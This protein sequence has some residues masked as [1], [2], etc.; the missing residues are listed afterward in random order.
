MS[1]K[2]LF[3]ALLV[4]VFS[5]AQSQRLIGVLSV[6]HKNAE[7]KSVSNLYEV[8]GSSERDDRYPE[9]RKMYEEKL[10]PGASAWFE[11]YRNCD[12]WKKII[13]EA[14]SKKARKN[15]IVDC[16]PAINDRGEP[17]QATAKKSGVALGIYLLHFGNKSANRIDKTLVYEV[18]GSAIKDEAGLA[19]ILAKRYGGEMVGYEFLRGWNCTGNAEAL[20]K[21]LNTSYISCQSVDTE[22]NN[23]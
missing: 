11:Y 21:R 18:K 20:K 23:N 22:G 17:L 9:L 1:Y 14:T 6:S 3:V 19:G 7:G 16:M 12:Q 10:G 15:L 4:L 8:Y 5:Q 13:Y 2:F